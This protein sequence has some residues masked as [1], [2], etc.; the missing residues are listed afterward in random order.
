MKH[1]LPAFAA[2]LL[3]CAGAWA[4]EH[5]PITVVPPGKG[6]YEFPAGYQIP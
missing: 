6:P 5:Y 3:S 2:I 4:Q 1:R